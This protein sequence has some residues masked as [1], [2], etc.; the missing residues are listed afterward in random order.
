MVLRDEHAA[1]C[2]DSTVRNYRD[3]ETLALQTFT[4]TDKKDTSR[5]TEISGNLL[6][7]LMGQIL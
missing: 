1:R 2:Q 6:T 3:L 4:V 7:P 5:I